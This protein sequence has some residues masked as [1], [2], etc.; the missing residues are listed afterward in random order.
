MR[1]DSNQPV[2]N[3]V[4]TERATRNAGKTGGS[5]GASSDGA[6]FSADPSGVSSLEAQVLATPEIRADRVAALR[7]AV[8]NG[9]Y[10][11]DPSKIADAILRESGR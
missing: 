3:Q 9:S 2:S 4:A 7:D 1:I 11:V 10:Q 8:R 6:T 5:A